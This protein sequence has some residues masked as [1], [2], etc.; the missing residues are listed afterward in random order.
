MKKSLFSIST[1]S[2]IIKH[3]SNI[4]ETKF[5]KKKIRENF[6]V[7]IITESPG[8]ISNS[9]EMTNNLGFEHRFIFDPPPA[10][11]LIIDEKEVFIKTSIEGDFGEK[12]SIWSNN[13]CILAICENYFETLWEKSSEKTQTDKR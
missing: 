10:H 2:Q 7:R 4:I 11:L 1:S 3:L 13:P 9:S 12:P 5:F 6:R 8:S